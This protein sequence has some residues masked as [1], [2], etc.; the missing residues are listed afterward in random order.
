MKKIIVVAVL[1]LVSVGAVQAQQHAAPTPEVA[2]KFVEQF[3]NATN[4]NWSLVGKVSVAQFNFMQSFRI[5]YY[6]RTGDLIAKGRKVKE[7]QLPMKV[8]E[9]LQ[10]TKTDWE[11]RSGTLI[12]GSIYEFSRPSGETEYVT[13]F[14]NNQIALTVLASDGKITIRK[15]V[16]K[17]TIEQPRELIAQ[18]LHE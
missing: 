13:T 14:E 5:A 8:Y 1:L 2:S 16:K 18:A 6:D 3:R 10:L 7:E 15:K 17:Y 4:V 11:S 9:D 12:G